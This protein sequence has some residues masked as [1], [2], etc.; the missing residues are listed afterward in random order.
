MLLTVDLA[1]CVNIVMNG[2]NILSYDSAPTTEVKCITISAN[3][4][5]VLGFHEV[6]T[7]LNDFSSS[8]L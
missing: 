1:V 6:K 4:L 3:D 8:S 7:T 2:V 5:S